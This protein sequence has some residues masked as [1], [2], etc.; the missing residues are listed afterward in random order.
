[1]FFEKILLNELEIQVEYAVELGLD[2][3]PCVSALVKQAGY[4][5]RFH[6]Q[7]ANRSS[8]DTDMESR[9]G[10]ALGVK[11]YPIKYSLGIINMPA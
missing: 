3:Q 1:M 5:R 9:D 7:P 4:R 6:V 8:Y 10:A 11:A 2:I